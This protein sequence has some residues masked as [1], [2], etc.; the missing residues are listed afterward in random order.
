MTLGRCRPLR[1]AGQTE[2]MQCDIQGTKQARRIPTWR[3]TCQAYDPPVVNLMLP[4]STNTIGQLKAGSRSRSFQDHLLSIT[5]TLG[6]NHQ[7]GIQFGCIVR[8]SERRP[9]IAAR[10][11]LRVPRPIVRGW[12]S[13][14]VRRRDSSLI[15]TSLLVWDTLFGKPPRLCAGHRRNHLTN[16]ISSHL[17]AP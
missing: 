16:P 8:A 10:S 5:L 6:L 1:P 17:A 13:L 4:M 12:P 9:E 14:Q 3:P 7:L 2:E 15:I 11:Q